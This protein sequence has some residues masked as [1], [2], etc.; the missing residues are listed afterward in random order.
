MH[1]LFTRSIYLDQNPGREF[2]GPEGIKNLGEKKALEF[3]ID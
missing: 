1:R 3:S 2:T